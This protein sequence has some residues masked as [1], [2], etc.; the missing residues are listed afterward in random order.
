MQYVT[1]IH[2]FQVEEGK[3]S[4]VTLGKFDALHRGHQ[5]LINRIREYAKDG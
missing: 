4:A 3:G 2:E 1:D 5:K